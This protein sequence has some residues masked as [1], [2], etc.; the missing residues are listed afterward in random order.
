MLFAT[1]NCRC[2]VEMDDITGQLDLL[3]MAK[4]FA[5][6]TS[7]WMWI[8]ITFQNMRQ[9]NMAANIHSIE[10]LSLSSA[11]TETVNSVNECS[12]SAAHREI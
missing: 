10:R 9:V 7:S 1:G 12:F 8:R 11:D 4:A 5:V 6:Y 3:D 2:R